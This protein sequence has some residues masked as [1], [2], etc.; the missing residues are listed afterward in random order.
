[1]SGRHHSAGPEKPAT[2]DLTG[3]CGASDLVRALPWSPAMLTAVLRHVTIL[4]VVVAVLGATAGAG[5]AGPAALAD[6]D[7]V[8]IGEFQDT[9]GWLALHQEV[10]ATVNDTTR[11]LVV[12]LPAK[13]G[14]SRTIYLERPKFTASLVVAP[15]TTPTIKVAIAGKVN[16]ADALRVVTPFQ[17]AALEVNAGAVPN[18]LSLV[19]GLSGVVGRLLEL[20]VSRP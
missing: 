16:G 6:V 8:L 12:T 9:G 4:L 10:L 14:G 2:H 13:T 7:V 19:Y 5:G 17:H 15:G 18:A 20:H 1:V 11:P 3:A